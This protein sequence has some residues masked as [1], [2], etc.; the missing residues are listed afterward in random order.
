MHLLPPSCTCSQDV[1]LRKMQSP[2]RL[3]DFIDGIFSSPLQSL[4]P[5]ALF[6][7]FV[8][9]K[10]CFQMPASWLRATDWNLKAWAQPGMDEAAIEQHRCVKTFKHCACFMQGKTLTGLSEITRNYKISAW[11][12]QFNSIMLTNKIKT[13]K[14]CWIFKTV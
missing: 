8:L 7:A 13:D 14:A 2:V 1:W 9:Y 11:F 3:L 6:G 5:T 10:A 4:H 12:G